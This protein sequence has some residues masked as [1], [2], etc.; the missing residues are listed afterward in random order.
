MSWHDDRN[1]AESIAA[2]FGVHPS[3]L[4]GARQEAGWTWS[5]TLHQLEQQWDA[6][7][8]WANG[9]DV[10]W[11]ALAGPDV[12]DVFHFYHPGA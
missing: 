9:D 12:P 1:E 11:D 7:L 2:T 10:D 6:Y 8:A 5:E 3:D 4:N